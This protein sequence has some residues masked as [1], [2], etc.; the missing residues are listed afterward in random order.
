M[1]NVRPDFKTKRYG[2][3]AAKRKVDGTFIL[4]ANDV[5]L[6]ML[7][8]QMN[9]DAVDMPTL[10]EAVS[11][12]KANPAQVFLC[13]NQEA[14]RAAAAEASAAAAAAAAKKAQ[15]EAAAAQRK[16]CDGLLS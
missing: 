6:S 14:Q 13:I 11:S 8:G 5:E 12:W 10:R 16:V 7:F 1:D 2:E 3:A 15:E 4:K 9:V